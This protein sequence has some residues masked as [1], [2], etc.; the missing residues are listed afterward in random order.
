MAH[1]ASP[2]VQTALFAKNFLRHPL[3]LGSFIPSSRFLIR[4]LLEEVDFGRARVIVEYGPGV[5][6]FTHE[7]LAR[8]RPDAILVALETNREFVHFLRRSTTDPRMHVVHGSAAAVRRA[9][10]AHGVAQADFVISGIPFSTL[11]ALEREA[12]VRAT[13][14]VLQ[15]HGAF[16]VYQF[17]PMVLANLRA[18]FSHVRR[19]FQ[20]L[21]M[22]PAQLFYCTP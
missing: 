22:P 2:L 10:L 16:L 17:S 3:M 1:R 14:A 21:N 7:I 9:L 12:V 4:T 11:P 20:P 6:T 19:G 5:G 13:H 15:P 8:M 18:V